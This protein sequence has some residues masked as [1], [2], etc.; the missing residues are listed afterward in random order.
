ML[1]ERCMVPIGWRARHGTTECGFSAATC[2][3]DNG[4]SVCEHCG[5][6]FCQYHMPKHVFVGSPVNDPT[7][8]PFETGGSS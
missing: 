6:A 1:V 5:W 3:Q 4:L 2:D 7:E 8:R